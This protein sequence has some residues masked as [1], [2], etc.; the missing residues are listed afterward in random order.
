MLDFTIDTFTVQRNKYM[1]F[2]PLAKDQKGITCRP[3]MLVINHFTPLLITILT[4]QQPRLLPTIFYYNNNIFIIHY[5]LCGFTVSLFLI[6]KKLFFYA[7]KH[8]L[9]TYGFEMVFR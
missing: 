7:V 4:P 5:D 3:V 2:I 6:T 9:V 1:R 8:L